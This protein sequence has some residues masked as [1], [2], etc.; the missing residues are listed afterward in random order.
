MNH[1]LRGEETEDFKD[2]IARAVGLEEYGSA[3]MRAVLGPD[4]ADWLSIQ[5]QGPVNCSAVPPHVCDDRGRR[6]RLLSV[7]DPQ[8]PRPHPRRGRQGREHANAHVWRPHLARAQQEQRLSGE[9]V[10][11]EKL[12]AARQRV[13]T[14]QRQLRAAERAAADEGGRQRGGKMNAG[15]NEQHMLA[16]FRRTPIPPEGQC[17]VFLFF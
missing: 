5:R 17:P 15:P 3:S 12:R 8:P 1:E 10:E 2:A 7:D 11:S 9:L 16:I 13:R 6:R 14:I 4:A